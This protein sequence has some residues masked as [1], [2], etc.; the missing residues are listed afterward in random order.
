MHHFSRRVGKSNVGDRYYVNEANNL[1][2]EDIK[3]EYRE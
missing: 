3:D 2:R 1:Y